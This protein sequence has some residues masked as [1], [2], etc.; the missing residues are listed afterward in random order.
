MSELIEERVFESLN[1]SFIMLILSSSDTRPGSLDCAAPPSCCFLLAYLPECSEKMERY[2]RPT[3]SE[4][5]SSYVVVYEPSLA[6]A[7]A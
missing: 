2:K 3:P 6:A 5:I 4:V 1:S 7:A